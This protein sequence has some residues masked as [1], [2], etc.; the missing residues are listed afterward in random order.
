MGIGLEMIGLSASAT[1][2]STNWRDS[3]KMKK[4]KT[5]VIGAVRWSPRSGGAGHVG[6][7]V[8]VAENGST[9][10]TIEGN[11]SD[12][13]QYRTRTASETNIT[14]VL[15]DYEKYGQSP[16]TV[17]SVARAQVGFKEGDGN[18]TP[19]GAW[20]GKN[21][22]AWCG[23]FLGWCFDCAYPDGTAVFQSYGTG[24]GMSPVD[25]GGWNQEGEYT[26][27]APSV[28]IDGIEYHG[29]IWGNS[30]LVTYFSRLSNG[31]YYVRSN[32]AG[33]I[34]VHNAFADCDIDTLANMVNSSEKAYNYGIDNNGTIGLFADEQLYTNSC[35]NLDADKYAINIVC[36]GT[37]GGFN[38][39]TIQSLVDLLEDVYRRNFIYLVTFNDNWED[40]LTLHSM[41]NKHVDCPGDTAKQ[42]LRG[43]VSELNR[44]LSAV[45]KTNFVQVGSQIA[46][47][48][49]LALRN[50]SLINVKQI[51]P[52][53]IKVET[54]VSPSQLNTQSLVIAGIVGVF[55]NLG[56]FDDENGYNNEKVYQLCEAITQTVISMPFGFLVTSKAKNVEELRKEAYYLKFILSKKP[57]KFGIWLEPDF[58]CAPKKI[59]EFVEQ[60][61]AFFVDWGF[62]SKCGLYCSRREANNIGW[63]TQATYMP[64]WLSDAMNDAVCPDDE[65]LTPTFFQLDDLSNYGI[66]K[67]GAERAIPTILG[68]DRSD[69]N[70]T[71]YDGAFKVAMIGDNKVISVPQVTSHRVAKK[72][73][74]YTAITNQSTMN[75][76]ITHSS[77]TITD[78][79]GFR[80]L[81]DRYLIAVGSGVCMN[82]GTYIDVILENGTTIPCI[83]GDGKADQHTDS[84]NIYTVVNDVWCCSEF[85]VD[86]PVAKEHWAK[87]GDASTSQPGWNSPVVQ[88]IVYSKR[89]VDLDR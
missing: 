54:N 24:I 9:I 42:Q 26:A 75:Y 28:G 59:P 63:P 88:F 32:R 52:Y 43:I 3:S 18:N 5:P 47:S 67:Y 7:V 51:R 72:W 50:Q 29:A 73:E 31:N 10:T 37:E 65:L 58:Q 89:I 56:V 86:A 36:A 39:S 57:P 1:A 41:Y 34:T 44:R 61:Y 33:H 11:S 80:K 82:C 13:V 35:D 17:I 6:L 49:T 23:S 53:V 60:W 76:K 71:E 81:N 85:I 70:S 38:E 4:L 87:S 68:F 8:A 30:S 55:F 19:Y 78:N 25:S 79:L 22:L 83:M 40:T 62:K 48:R 69:S 20:N 12:S 2:L 84:N 21:G 27:P 16:E 14:Y 66:S 15:P 45:V 77:K 64:L 46:E 74:S